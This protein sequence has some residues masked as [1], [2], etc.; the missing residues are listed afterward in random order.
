MCR[1]GSTHEQLMSTYQSVL[2]DGQSLKVGRRCCEESLHS[3]S[4]IQKMGMC[5]TGLAVNA[6]LS[7]RF[8]SSPCTPGSRDRMANQLLQVR[9]VGRAGNAAYTK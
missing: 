5:R 7:A 9:Q 4:Y 2:F 3:F 8:S 1:T 6:Y